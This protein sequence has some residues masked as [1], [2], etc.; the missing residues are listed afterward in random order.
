[1]CGVEVGSLTLSPQGLSL[2]PDQC[3]CR[4][5]PKIRQRIKQLKADL[6]L[7]GLGSWTEGKRGFD[8]G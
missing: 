2:F 5:C 3:K 6:T 4:C 8:C 1:M 7:Q